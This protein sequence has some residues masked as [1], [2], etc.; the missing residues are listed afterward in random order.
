MRRDLPGGGRVHIDRPLPFLCLHATGDGHQLAALDVATAN[1]SYL[2]APDVRAAAPLLDALG[3]AML[4]KFGAFMVIEVAE[5][6]EDRLLSPDS[7]YL[8]PFETS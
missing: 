2:I 1:A 8:P 6:D 3:R 7:P 4:R 5:L